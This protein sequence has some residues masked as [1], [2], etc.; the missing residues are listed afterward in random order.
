V[1]AYCPGPPRGLRRD[2]ALTGPAEVATLS[3]VHVGHASA[4]LAT[5]AGK[6]VPVTA[7][8]AG[9]VPGGL[10]LPDQATLSPVLARWSEL[11]DGHR[12]DAIDLRAWH[13]AATAVE[14]RIPAAARAGIT[15]AQ[16][17]ELDRGLPD[18]PSHDTGFVP[19]NF[20]P[21]ERAA[22][23]ARHAVEDLSGELEVCVAA[24]VGAGVGTT[25]A[26]DDVICGVLA[27]LDLL[28]H[29]GAH[30]RLDAAVTPL[31]AATTR[32][33]RHLLVAAAAGRYTEGLI[34]LAAAQASASASAVHDALGALARWGASSGLDQAI[35]FAAAIRAGWSPA[36]R[37]PAGTLIGV[38]AR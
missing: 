25:P 26:G 31:L 22:E 33:S 13:A 1:L 17:A 37:R 12:A 11:A 36:L 3:V 34:G 2:R 15:A 32:T 9:L 30:D 23:L 8:P 4:L 27:G 21:A 35:G 28:G 24:T 10:G 16:L 18:R 38:G 20:A 7:G 29:A 14:L 5:R 6:L 19:T